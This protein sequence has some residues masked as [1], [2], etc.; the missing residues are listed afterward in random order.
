MANTH[1]TFKLKD[2]IRRIEGWPDYFISQGGILYSCKRVNQAFAA[3]GMYPIKTKLN[4]KGYPEAGLFR[5]ENGKKI[6]KFFRIHQLVVN[7]WVDKPA[8]WDEK[9]YEANHKNGIKTDNRAENL[10]WMT[11]SENLK[12]SYHVLGREKLLRPITYDGIHYGS[13]VEFC[14]RNSFN[15]KSVNTVLSRGSKKYFGKEIKYAGDKA[16]MGKTNY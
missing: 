16:G 9:V 4:S 5:D 2:P 3:G 10:E 14:K 7:T 15:Q 11:R 12:H 1:T 6:R 13:I 8:D